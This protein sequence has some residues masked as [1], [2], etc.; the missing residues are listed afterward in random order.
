MKIILVGCGT[1]GATI[2]SSLVSEG[3]DIVAID[4]DADFLNS[5]TNVYDVMGL[6][7]NGADSDV[8]EEAGADTADLF[9]AVTGSDELNML[10]CF[11]ARKMGAKYTI[12][13][14][15]SPEYNDKSLGFMKDNLELSMC[16]NPELLTARELYKILKFPSAVKIETFSRGNL[17]MIEIRLKSDST[18]D[19]MSLMEM[20]KTHK[21][22]VLVCYV[23]R[24]DEVFIPDGN[25]R[26]KSGDWVG[27]T[28]A[29]GELQKLFKSL[30][31][32]QKQAKNVMLLGGS[33]TAHYLADMLLESGGSVKIIERNPEICERLSEAL[34]KAVIL[35]GDGAEQELLLEEG[36]RSLDAFVS[37]TNTDEANILLSIFASGQSVPKVIAKV[38]REELVRMAENMGLDSVVSPKAM[39]GDVIVSYA[40]ALENSKGSNVETLYKIAD[41]KAE[42][43]EFNVRADSK[44]IGVPLKELQIKKGILIAGIIRNRKTVIPVGD[45]MIL[46]GDSVV[47]VAADQGLRDLDG[48]L[49]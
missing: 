2:I 40:R 21:A 18:L 49:R 26:L 15:R 47:I 9:V 22:K 34:P 32:Y 43:L 28:A 6:C 17:E 1:I 13:R 31:V 20:R 35:N 37:L 12:A 44:V 25:F 33:R 42:A 4:S 27:I 7:G 23:R 38:N 41:G 48:I 24:D 36:L 14:V 39:V 11:L 8:L 10:S 5:I 46:A 30:G 45:D 16:I 3:H 29:P 19:G